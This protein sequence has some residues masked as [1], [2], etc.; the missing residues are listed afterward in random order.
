MGKPLLLVV[1]DEDALC[2]QIKWGL[3]DEY[4]VITAHDENEAIEKFDNNNPDI[5]TLDLNLSRDNEHEKGFFVLKH[6]I[7]LDPYA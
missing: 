7:S 2:R 4:R 5:I 3:N 6:I 1:D